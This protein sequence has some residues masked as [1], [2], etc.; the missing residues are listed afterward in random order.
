MWSRVLIPAMNN[1]P[2]LSLLVVLVLVAM[3]LTIAGLVVGTLFYG[4][5]P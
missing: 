2:P 1:S 3:I 5:A 4:F